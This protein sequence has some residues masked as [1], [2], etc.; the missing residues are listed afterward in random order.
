MTDLIGAPAITPLQVAYRPE[1]IEGLLRHWYGC[2]YHLR[3]AATFLEKYHLC[4]IYSQ[5]LAAEFVTVSSLVPWSHHSSFLL[6]YDD[7]YIG[8][9]C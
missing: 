7:A 6:V 1:S 4:G 5:C 2:G 9:L 8:N 3:L